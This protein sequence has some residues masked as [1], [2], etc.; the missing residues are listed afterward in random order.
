MYSYP[1]YIYMEVRRRHSD[2][3]LCVSS[4][5][6]YSNQS[7]ANS[8]TYL[9]ASPIPVINLSVTL[10]MPFIDNTLAEILL[11]MD[12]FFIMSTGIDSEE[13]L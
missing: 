5:S 9:K 12:T 7:E 4:F 2:C 6:V 10:I 13:I 8:D 1:Y 3:D 11:R